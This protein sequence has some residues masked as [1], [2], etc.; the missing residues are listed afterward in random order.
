MSNKITNTENSP[1]PE[2]LMG[3]NPNAIEAQEKQG[4]DELTAKREICQLPA[5]INPNGWPEHE[6]P[7]LGIEVIGRTKGDNLF[8][9]VRLPKGWEIKPTAHSMWSELVDET[10]KERAS[11]FYKAAFYDREAFININKQ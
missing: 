1:R 10:G 4:Q 3:G 6:Y 11:I 9:D 7:K 5:K 8:F 2:W